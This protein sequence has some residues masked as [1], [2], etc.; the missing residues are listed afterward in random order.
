MKSSKW[1]HHFEILGCFGSGTWPSWWHRAF[2]L[3]GCVSWSSRGK[4]PK[5]DQEA[6][7]PSWP[8][9]KDLVADAPSKLT[10]AGESLLPLMSEEVL[11]VPGVHGFARAGFI[12]KQ[13]DP[14]FCGH[15]L[16]KME[17]WER[18]HCPLNQSG[19]LR[20]WALEKEESPYRACLDFSRLQIIVDYLCC[21]TA[22][23]S[24]AFGKQLCL[25]RSSY[26]VLG[27][28]EERNV[29]RY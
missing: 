22:G 6:G 10:G 18:S 9:Q 26:K 16:G 25:V 28:R 14:Y 2:W 1:F 17:G 13:F 4:V 7:W 29:L 8:S 5:E 19:K 11:H 23:T 3:P 15:G 24:W 21:S 20:N 27:G 12:P